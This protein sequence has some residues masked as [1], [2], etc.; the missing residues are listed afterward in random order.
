MFAVGMSLLVQRTEVHLSVQC[1]QAC[2]EGELEE[3][4]IGCAAIAVNAKHEGYSWSCWY[5]QRPVLK[6]PFASEK[7]ETAVF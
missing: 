6:Y 7:E 1:K 2:S 5:K 3:F 4:F